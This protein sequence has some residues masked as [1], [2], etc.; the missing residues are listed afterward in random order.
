V[1]V[2][3]LTEGFHTVGME[4]TPDGYRFFVDGR[5]TWASQ[6]AVSQVAEYLILSG[7]V[8]EWPGEIRRAQLPDRVIFDWVRVWQLPVGEE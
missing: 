5:Q 6:E 2:P 8:S 7:E 1:G 4:W 3:G